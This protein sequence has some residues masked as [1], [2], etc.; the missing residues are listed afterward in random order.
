MLILQMNA[1][2]R[3][4]NKLQNDIKVVFIEIYS[5]ILNLAAQ[6]HQIT[7]ELGLATIFGH[8][9]TFSPLNPNRFP[10]K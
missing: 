10:S 6:D 8:N 7:V 4:E 1:F 2:Y 5:K 9:N 3:A